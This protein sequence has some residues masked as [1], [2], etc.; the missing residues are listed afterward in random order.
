MIK[1]II[2][3]LTYPKDA[4]RCELGE[5]WVPCFGVPALDWRLVSVVDFSMPY[6][7]QKIEQN[8]IGVWSVKNCYLSKN[9]P[10]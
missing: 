4:V 2:G 8:R 9:D 5:S 1:Q 10:L 6:N 7:Y 3:W